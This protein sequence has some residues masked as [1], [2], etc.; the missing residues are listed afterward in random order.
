MKK[1]IYVQIKKPLH[2]LSL[3]HWC[4]SEKNIIV[5]N[6]N[7]SYMRSK[8][9][10]LNH[11]KCKIDITIL[12]RVLGAWRVVVLYWHH[13]TLWWSI[14]HCSRSHYSIILYTLYLGSRIKYVRV[15]CIIVQ[16]IAVRGSRI[17]NVKILCNIRHYIR[18]WCETDIT[19]IGQHNTAWHSS[20]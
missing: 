4:I 1:K 2:K 12:I 14:V 9:N 16:V 6:V 8:I 11:Q 7:E 3:Y 5:Y 17:N 13:Q 15:L 19:F 18:A 10:I 20:L